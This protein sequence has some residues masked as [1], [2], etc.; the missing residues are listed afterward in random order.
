[1]CFRRLNFS[2]STGSSFLSPKIKWMEFADYKLC[3]GM[4][5]GKFRS[6]IQIVASCGHDG[7]EEELQTVLVW[8]SILRLL[9]FFYK[10][11]VVPQS[12]ILLASLL[13]RV[14]EGTDRPREN[15]SSFT[16]TP[17][18]CVWLCVE[19]HGERADGSSM[20]WECSS[21]AKNRLRKKQEVRSMKESIFKF[22]PP[23]VTLN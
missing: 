3:C 14:L 1:M 18:T 15:G 16:F 19:Q 20:N 17:G 11:T 12:E 13:I 5:R 10:V 7:E 22:L 6:E 2:W 9:L 8:S 4:E 21:S 23:Q